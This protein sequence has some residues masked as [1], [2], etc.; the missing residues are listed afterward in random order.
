M[1]PAQCFSFSVIL[2]NNLCISEQ[3]KISS[4]LG[5]LQ[6]ISPSASANTLLV[7]LG[8]QLV[9]QQLAHQSC[10]VV[11]RTRD[12]GAEHSP[13]DTKLSALSQF[14]VLLSHRATSFELLEPEWVSKELIWKETQGMH[15]AEDITEQFCLLLYLTAERHSRTGTVLSFSEK[16]LQHLLPFDPILFIFVPLK[17]GLKQMAFF[18]CLFPREVS[19]QTLRAAV[20]LKTCFLLSEKRPV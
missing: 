12:I 19:S 2:F 6:I 8:K 17:L 18:V 10:Y 16:S 7:R 4:R 15:K 3:R 5:K 1:S 20:S 13:K 14:W 9:L 11:A